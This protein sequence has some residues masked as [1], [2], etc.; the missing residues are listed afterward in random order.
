MSIDD[1]LLHFTQMSKDIFGNNLTGIYLH[2]SYSLGCF[3]PKKSDLD[4]LLV[5]EDDISDEQKMAFMKNVVKMNEEAPTKGIELSI[6]KRE[7]CNPFVYPTPFELHFSNMHKSW[8][9]TNPEEYIMKMKGTDRDLAAHVT[10][11]NQNAVVLYG[12]E[13]KDVFGNVPKLNYVDSIWS[14][15]KEAK[16]DILTDPMYVTLTL[17]RVLGYLK[18]NLILSKQTGGEWG[19]K[20]LPQEFHEL[21]QEALICYQTDRKMVASTKVANEYVEYMIDKIEECKAILE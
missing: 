21:I 10:I 3:N 1:L 12:A 8:F 19:I 15:I 17:C 6:L 13:V 5:I 20:N 2:G 7:F 14:D 18:E 9:Q 16:V 11:I 4:L